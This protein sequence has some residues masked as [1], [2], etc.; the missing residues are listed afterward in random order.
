MT[1]TRRQFLMRSGVVAGGVV[2]LS[3]CG[4]VPVLPTFAGPEGD[5][6]YAWVQVTSTGDVRFLCPRSEMGQGIITSLAQVVAEEMG[7]E[8]H[9]V[10]C[11]YPNTDQIRPAKMTVGSES[12]EGFFEPLALAAAALR[13]TLR[14]RAASH[15]DT[16]PARVEL[17][18][19]AFRFG[20]RIVSFAELGQQ[21]PLEI[22]DA[23][24]L[25]PPPT[26]FSA[27]ASPRIVGKGSLPVHGEAIVTGREV[28][29]RDVRIEGLVFGA[30]A[31]PPWLGAKLLSF[32]KSSALGTNGVIA[33]VEG[34]DKQVGVVAQNPMAMREGLAALDCQWEPLSEARRTEI[35]EVNDIDRCVE[36]DQLDHRPVD[37]GDVLLGMRDAAHSINVRYDTPMAAHASMEPR[38]GVAYFKN[39]ICFVHTGSQD[40]W[41][42]R[43]AVAR[44]TGLAEKDVV[45]QNHRMGGGFGGR[46]H[47]QAS[48]EAAWLAKAVDRPVKVQWTREEEMTR[49]YAGPAFSHRIR[50]GVDANGSICSWHHQMVGSPILTTSALIPAHLHWAANL[51]ADPGTWR[52]AETSYQLTNQLVEFADIRRPMPTGAWRGLGAAPNTFAVECAIDEL[53]LT[54]NLDPI[55]FRMRHARST[56]LVGVLERLRESVE[57]ADEVVGI[58]AGAYKGVTFVA[59]AA[60]I[61]TEGKVTRLWCVHDCGRMLNPDRV[62]AQVEGCLVW[63]VGMALHESFTVEQGIGTS[64]NFSRYSV[65][66]IDDVPA[67]NIDL[68]ESDSPPSGAGEAALPPAAA[69]IVNALARVKERQRRLPVS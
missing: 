9:D 29:S 56:R 17:D 52:G 16:E 6:A 59:V 54:A 44:A 14:I 58:A 35:D 12:V 65:P 34:P 53:A 25:T 61:N 15:F 8:I 19:K 38:S 26:L 27:M 47:C 18:R 20:S 11:V 64:D 55:E 22:L 66:R 63:G 7:T 37:E 21:A 24:A 50:A 49:N 45:V 32:E 60:G 23:G 1:M 28:Y 68:I 39:K 3:S 41:Y 13:E 40:P 67:M 2:A 46:I 42:V 43:G 36:A 48:V 4:L 30:V 62:R 33:V 10:E 69:A 5:D 31:R 51:V 57:G